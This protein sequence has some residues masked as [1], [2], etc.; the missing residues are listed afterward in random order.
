[1]SKLDA[2]WA[3]SWI[4]D[5]NSH[6]VEAVLAHYVDACTFVSP[7]AATIAGTSVIEGK[8]ALRAYW[9]R[10]LTA[11]PHLRFTLRRALWDESERTLAILYE[12]VLDP[13]AP[14]ILVCEVLTFGADT[15]A[16]RGEAFYGASV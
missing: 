7:K 16:M 2:S 13:A 14:P 5:W 3:D 15:R 10:G 4:T 1:M 6:D 9:T 8:A 11:Y 12:A